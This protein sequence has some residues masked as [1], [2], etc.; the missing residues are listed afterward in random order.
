MLHLMN[1]LSNEM[2]KA[3][4]HIVVCVC[5]FR[6]SVNSYMVLQYLMT[7]KAPLIVAYCITLHA[8]TEE[9]SSTNIWIAQTQ[10]STR[11][12]ENGS[13]ICSV[14]RAL[15]SHCGQENATNGNFILN[16]YFLVT[17]QSINQ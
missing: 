8:S 7:I 1:P 2:K 4:L 16:F 17:M 3:Y 6:I 12:V 10:K 9:R 15:H 11:N 14:S 5:V 13:Q